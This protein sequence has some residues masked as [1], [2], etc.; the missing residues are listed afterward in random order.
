MR[1]CKLRGSREG[2]KSR[3]G[4]RAG[5]RGDLLGAYFLKRCAHQRWA[6]FGEG[7][8]SIYP[9]ALNFYTSNDEENDGAAGSFTGS[10][11]RKPWKGTGAPRS[12][13]SSSTRSSRGEGQAPRP[14]KRITVR[15]GRE[16]EPEKIE[17]LIE[18]GWREAIGWKRP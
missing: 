11:C 17:K 18:K 14:S 4:R 5:T 6:A 2:T 3:R 16:L 12:F 8:E 9:Q 15:L 1:F 7:L 10:S 13:P